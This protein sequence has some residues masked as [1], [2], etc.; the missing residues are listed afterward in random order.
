MD[1]QGWSLLAFGATCDAGL[2]E[3]ALAAHAA[4][5]A[6][7]PPPPAAASA[8]LRVQRESLRL[9]HAA[10]ALLKQPGAG[11]AEL[12]QA[13][14]DAFRAEA[15]GDA[16]AGGRSVPLGAAPA[17]RAALALAPGAPAPAPDGAA[18]EIDLLHSF[19]LG[20][21]A[22][23]ARAVAA[24]A[25]AHVAIVLLARLD[26]A[27][28]RA[29]EWWSEP[30]HGAR[31]AA[32]LAELGVARGA[33]AGA[34]A[35]ARFALLAACAGV[36][37][38]LGLDPAPAM[39]AAAAVNPLALRTAASV[40]ELRAAR[41]PRRALAE[42]AAALRRAER[43]GHEFAAALLATRA[44][45]AILAGASGPSFRLGAA[46]ALTRRARLGLDASGEAVPGAALEAARRE[47]AG[48]EAA[49]GV[50]APCA[51][52]DALRWAMPVAV[53]GAAFAA[54]AR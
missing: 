14:V 22:V 52:D 49:L 16:V 47:L 3:E 39:A 35:D 31:L 24:K 38:D 53:D 36:A 2:L 33:S 23:S 12:A 25:P 46:R 18:P 27:L 6:A 42:A 40:A 43:A 20:G 10:A 4:A 5:L 13:A 8:D 17:L 29:A 54:A 34:G 50:A 44:A 41:D 48:L 28:A 51:A 9:R 15:L 19:A 1:A 7:R 32:C 37:T 21:Q 11:V 45:F 30:A 26:A